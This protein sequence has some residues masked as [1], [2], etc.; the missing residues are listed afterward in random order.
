MFI[1]EYDKPGCCGCAI[2]DAEYIC[3]SCGGE[4][5]GSCTTIIKDEG[6]Y[7]KWCARDFMNE[8]DQIKFDK[9]NRF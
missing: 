3:D 6:H 1:E 8:E 7:C 4:R 2:R 9:K 5:C